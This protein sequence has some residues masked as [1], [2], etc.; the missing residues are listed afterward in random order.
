GPLKWA[1]T[2]PK[3][4]G[5]NQSPIDIRKENI[6]FSTHL[7]SFELPGYDSIPSGAHWELH[8]TGHL[9][10][11]RMNG[12]YLVSEGGLSGQYKA[13][14]MDFRWGRNEKKG[15]EHALNGTKYPMEV[16]FFLIISL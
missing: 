15:S 11:I 14:Q 6:R 9:L 8:N 12:E 10:Q 7:L 5:S 16:F 1:N 13:M 2:Y 3:C 4:S